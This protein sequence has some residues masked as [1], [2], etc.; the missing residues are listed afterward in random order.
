LT[1]GEF[2]S[3][4]GGGYVVYLGRT[5]YNSHANFQK[6][7][8]K[9]WINSDSRVIFIEFL[10]YNA[11]FNIFNAVKLIVEQSVSGY[12]YKKIEVTINDFAYLLR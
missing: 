5:L 11:N 1:L 3:Y 9:L 8:K 2:S 7:F 6:I 4:S 12:T 10:I